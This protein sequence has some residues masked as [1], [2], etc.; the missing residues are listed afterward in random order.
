M[1]SHIYCGHTRTNNSLREG[2]QKKPLHFCG[3]TSANCWCSPAL[4]PRHPAP[5]R[6]VIQWVDRQMDTAFKVTEHSSDTYTSRR[7]LLDLLDSLNF[8]RT[9][10]YVP[11]EAARCRLGAVANSLASPQ[12]TP[13]TLTSSQTALN[14]TQS[15]RKILQLK[16]SPC[17]EQLPLQLHLKL[18][19][20]S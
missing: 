3:E 9:V 13:S 7:V 14:C 17:R 16:Q 15:I 8:G 19:L 12:L 10:S 11:A 1:I 6:M 2:E 20:K 18:T 5:Y 4:L